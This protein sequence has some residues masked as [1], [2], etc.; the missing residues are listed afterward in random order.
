MIDWDLFSA[1]VPS[2]ALVRGDESEDGS[3]A[4]EGILLENKPHHFEDFIA[5]MWSEDD[6]KLKRAIMPIR[7]A[8]QDFDE[9]EECTV[10]VDF[11]DVRYFIDGRWQ[12]Y[13]EV[14]G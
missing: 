3:G 13:A 5:K 6:K 2:G 8:M 10:M 9:V 7:L 1:R 4:W 11:P 14:M 12:S